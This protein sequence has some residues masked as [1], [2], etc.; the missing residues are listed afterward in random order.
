MKKILALLI[1]LNLGW[2]MQGQET[3]D[4]EGVNA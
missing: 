1:C 3:K 4:H 2:K